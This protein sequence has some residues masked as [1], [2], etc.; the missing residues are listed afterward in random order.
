LFFLS[1]SLALKKK[2]KL[3]FMLY[4]LC[5]GQ[6]CFFLGN[7]LHFFLSERYDFKH[8]KDFF[9][10]KEK[11]KLPDFYKRFQQVAKI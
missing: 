1:L 2:A 7:F 3:G 9:Q 8:I 6:W 5:L 4:T 10:K 11:E